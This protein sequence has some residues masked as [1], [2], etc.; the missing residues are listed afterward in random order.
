MDDFLAAV[1]GRQA[2]NIIIDNVVVRV[3][4]CRLLRHLQLSE[5]EIKI[6][7]TSEPV[8][9]S[10]LIIEYLSVAGLTDGQLKGASTYEMLDA[11]F[12][13]RQLNAWQWLLPWLA[14]SKETPGE[15]EFYDYSGRRWAVWV[16]RLAS[17]YG[18]S[19]D[20]IFNLWPEE[21]AA[22]IQEIM[23]SEYYERE[24]KRALSELSYRY[25]KATKVSNF[26]PTPTYSWMVD[27]SNPAPMRTPVR[28]LPVGNVVSMYS[29][30]DQ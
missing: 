14:N 13:L 15:P 29:E 16:H 8:L 24:D 4:R 18:W 26:I 2:V 7:A 10:A 11:F 20:Q 22:Y 6:K 23:V 25:D 21:A 3:A 12:A 9:K 1:D 17:R 27:E 19:R 28:L 30:E 5:I